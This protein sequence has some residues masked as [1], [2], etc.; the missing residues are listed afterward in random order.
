MNPEVTQTIKELNASL[1]QNREVKQLMMEDYKSEKINHNQLIQSISMCDKQEANIS[2][3]I[4]NILSKVG[5]VNSIKNNNNKKTNAKNN[6]SKQKKSNQK[7]SNTELK[8]T[9][10]DEQKKPEPQ[11]SQSG[12]SSQK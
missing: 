9:N 5:N 1:Q 11:D 3:S 7:A 8:A 6:N 10:A 4:A 12:D 2:Q